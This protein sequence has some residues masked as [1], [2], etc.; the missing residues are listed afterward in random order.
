M[1]VCYP[2]RC[3]ALVIT[4]EKIENPAD[5]QVGP[6]KRVC[7]VCQFEFEYDGDHLVFLSVNPDGTPDWWSSG[8]SPELERYS[9]DDRR[10]RR[11]E[12]HRVRVD[13]VGLKDLDIHPHIP[14]EVA[15]RTEGPGKVLEQPD[16]EGANDDRGHSP[17]A[18]CETE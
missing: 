14:V 18:A 3:G 4:D 15:A 11:P 1:N 12:E 17:P 16:G 2:C 10:N 5:V 9:D 7:D 6:R 13:R 8:G